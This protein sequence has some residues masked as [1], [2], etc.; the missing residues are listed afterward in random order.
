MIPFNYSQ[1]L[2]MS[3]TVLEPQKL[4]NLLFFLILP[5]DFNSTVSL[6]LIFI[7]FSL[8]LN[9]LFVQF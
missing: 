1:I 7:N 5:L 4:Y 3:Y 2:T 6:I 8:K 9:M